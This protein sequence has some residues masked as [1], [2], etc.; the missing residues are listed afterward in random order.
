MA[1]E[2]AFDFD[3][4]TRTEREQMRRETRKAIT[5][6]EDR[7]GVTLEIKNVKDELV[8]G[9]AGRPDFWRETVTCFVYNIERSDREDIQAE[10]DRV[11]DA[12]GIPPQTGRLILPKEST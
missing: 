3:F 1:T 9:K 7:N 2:T 10:T 8:K 6:Y 11:L 12:E 4:Q 5:F